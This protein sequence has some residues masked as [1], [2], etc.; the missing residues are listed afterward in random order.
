MSIV[1]IILLICFIPA[2][3]SGLRKGLIAQLIAIISIFA[4][5]W[6][7]FEFASITSQWLS[8]YIE[9]PENVLEIVAFALIMV[10]VFVTLGIIGKM[11]EG[12]LNLVMLGWANKLLG[13]AFAFVKSALVTGLL[14][15]VFNSINTSFDL[16]SAETLSE[17]VLYTPLKDFADS[18][19]PYIKEMISNI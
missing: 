7:S 12:I 13:V 9:A 2:L 14:I 4:G 8:Q 19:F 16:V 6:V 15:M 3:I 10:G 11:L 18:V 1:D 17:S 5:I